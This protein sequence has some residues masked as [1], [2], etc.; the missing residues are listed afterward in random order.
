MI[1]DEHF[2]YSAKENNGTWAYLLNG[3]MNEESRVTQLHLGG[4]SGS[5]FFII[6]VILP[7]G[8]GHRHSVR[9]ISRYSGS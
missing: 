9:F 8:K 5:T 2:S 3:G 4:N 7:F 1:L 6:N